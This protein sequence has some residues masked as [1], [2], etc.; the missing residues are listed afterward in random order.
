MIQ[1]WVLPCLLPHPPLG[2]HAILLGCIVTDPTVSP[3]DFQ[4]ALNYAV[5]RSFNFISVDGD[6]PMNDTVV[7]LGNR[8]AQP[9]EMEIDQETEWEGYEVFRDGLMIFA[10]DGKG[11]LSS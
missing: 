4:T 8:D 3:T 1:I 6:M 10:Q 7:V 11:G 9:D 2:R 5:D